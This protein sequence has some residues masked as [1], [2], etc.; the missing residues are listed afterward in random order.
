MIGKILGGLIGRKLDRRDGQGGIK[1]ALMGV[2]T[3]SIIRRVGPL[4]L[5]AGGAWIAKKAFDRHKAE[6]Q[7]ADALAADI[8]PTV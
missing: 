3:A 8:P 1:G 4:G 2:A 6:R 7:R 5:L